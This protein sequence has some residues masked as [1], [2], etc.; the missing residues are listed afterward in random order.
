MPKLIVQLA[1]GRFR[2]LDLVR[3]STLGRHPDQDI[4]VMDPLVSKEHLIIEQLAGEW[5]LRDLESRNGTWVNTE[6]V[7]GRVRLQHNDRIKV[8]TTHLV[9]MNRAEWRTPGEHTVTIAHALE[10]AIQNSIY[11]ESADEFLPVDIIPS[12]DTLRRDYEKLRLA[13]R[14]H[15]DIAF[16]V[17][18]DSL[19]PRILEHLFGL[20]KADRGVILLSDVG[21]LEPR[22]VKLRGQ[23][24]AAP[25]ELSQTI[26]NKVVAERTAV[27]TRD[28]QMDD[29]F[30][31]ADSVIIQGI[32]STMCVPLLARDSTVLGI[33]HLDSLVVA[34][35]F[36]ERDLGMLQAVAMQAS[37]AIENSRLVE[38][39][40]REAILRQRLE[41]MLS[42]SLVNRVVQ[43]D[44]KIEKG[45]E[46]REVVVMFVDIRDFSSV[47]ERMPPH[48]VMGLLNECFE[49][50]VDAVFEFD[51]TLDK[52][53][54]DGL[55]AIWGAPVADVEAADKAL[56]CAVAMQQ[57]LGRFNTLRA[58]DQ[59]GP[60]QVGIGID[61]GEAVVG[62]VGSS[63]TLSY[64]AIG[65][66]VNIASR[67]CGLAS[68]G[69]TLVSEAVWRG[70]PGVGDVAFGTRREPLLLKGI[71]T[72]VETWSVTLG[73]P[74][75]VTTGEHPV[76]TLDEAGLPVVS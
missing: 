72:P 28:A 2:E 55:M 67:L 23:D 1:G 49:L 11:R 4:Q 63:R 62:Y 66:T 50:L 57:T 10:P 61:R 54:G 30:H 32:R 73:E 25:I 3:V 41:K 59:K 69:E 19:L 52:F 35:A 65:P 75:V 45:G 27:L 64:T 29:R 51:G 20:F 18:L 43:G 58:L 48:E 47:A 39:T 53:L 24:E 6:R 60:V 13:A 21:R 71:S 36:T 31:L 34:N 17:K 70:A 38:R 26:I 5:Y 8:G 74:A 37:I 14:L 76:L 7:R 44:V 40:E 68:S 56:R 16:D 33:I 12:V 22:A 15:R 9:F 42:P 46:L